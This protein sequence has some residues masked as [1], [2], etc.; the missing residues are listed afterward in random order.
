[1]PTASMSLSPIY[2]PPTLTL[3]C[4]ILDMSDR[5]FPV[6]IGDDCTIGH[7]KNEIVKNNPVSFEGV[8]A[9]VLDLWEV[10]GFPP[11]ST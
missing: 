1:M 6:D 11:F 5:S 2:Q 9:Y 3:F 7:L 4:W 10:S 8:D